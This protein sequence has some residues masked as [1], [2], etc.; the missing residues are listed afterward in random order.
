MEHS[1]PKSYNE[2][3]PIAPMDRSRP[4]VLRFLHRFW[5]MWV[6]F[7]LL[8]ARVYTFLF[9]TIFYFTLVPLTCFICLRDPLKQ[10]RRE[11]SFWESRKPVERSLRRHTFQF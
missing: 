2:P 8:C 11:E 3:V 6:A 9:L 4:A 7:G 10:R 5:R 1:L